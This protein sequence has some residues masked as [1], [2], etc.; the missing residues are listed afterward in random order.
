MA[1]EY[2]RH[3]TGEAHGEGSRGSDRSVWGEISGKHLIAALSTAVQGVAY[4]AVH[5]GVA[6]DCVP[7]TGD[8]EVVLDVI[9]GDASREFAVAGGNGCICLSG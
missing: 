8:G 7:A 2:R 4:D 5:L 1:R 6:H 9:S 3:G